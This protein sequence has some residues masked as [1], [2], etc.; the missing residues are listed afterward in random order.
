MP[1]VLK[2]RENEQQ[3]VATAMKPLFAQR[4]GKNLLIHGPPG[5]GKTLAVRHVIQELEEQTDDI[6]TVFVN[7]WQYNTSYK[8]FV[9][10]CEQLGFKFTQNKKTTELQKVALRLLNEQPVVIVFDEVDK[11]EDKDFLYV[12][13]EGVYHKSILLITNYK[14]LLFEVDERIRSRLTPELLEFK[15]YT[16]TEIK[17]I[18]QER[19]ELGFVPGCFSPD[20][21]NEVA[22]RTYGIKDIRSGLFLLKTSALRAEEQSQKKISLEEVQHAISQ[23]DEFSAKQTDELDDDLQFILNVVKQ[24]SGKKIGDMFKTYESVG[25][26]ASYKTFQRKINKLQEGR[27]IK[28]TK[29]TGAGG[30][31][32]I[33]EK[34]ITDF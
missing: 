1:K 11:A 16:L 27:F 17:D 13:V 6:T 24:E 21:L 19:V 22:T 34:K 26:K 7:C 23:L 8:I 5:I 28:V 4:N 32:T 15:E 2:H 29:Q 3:Y 31:T 10:I 12:L 25:G 14:S 30:N 9:E 33:I 18:L 20:A